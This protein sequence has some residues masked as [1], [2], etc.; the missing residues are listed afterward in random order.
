[1]KKFIIIL[2]V[3]SCLFCAFACKK[4]RLNNSISS[5]Q[6]NS[7]ESSKSHSST[8]TNNSDSAIQ[9][10][11]VDKSSNTISVENSSVSS[12][13]NSSSFTIISSVSVS[14]TSSSSVVESGKG[15]AI[16]SVSSQTQSSSSSV[17]D[18]SSL[19]ESSN[20]QS[21]SLSSNI[22]SSSI[23]SS[24]FQIPLYSYSL[25]VDP[26]S[27]SHY[28]TV[29]LF[30]NGKEVSGVAIGEVVEVEI[31]TSDALHRAIGVVIING[32]TVFNKNEYTQRV[33]ASGKMT[34]NGLQIT[35]KLLIQF[36]NT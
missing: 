30:Q 17:L 33:T 6:L 26:I 5:S 2:L 22:S 27:E 12:A 34:E 36:S 11:I 23:E 20:K 18:S 21:S 3:I 9:S 28:V 8:T 4:P 29:K 19:S 7:L 14:S 13:V 15:S 32:T 16:S 1:M 35:V 25:T 24:S 10:S 31:T